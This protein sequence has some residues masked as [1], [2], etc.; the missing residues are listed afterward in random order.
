M[1]SYTPIRFEIPT[2]LDETGLMLGLQRLPEE[3]L[4]TYRK[5]LLLETTE[6]SGPS[7]HQFITAVGRK[8]GQFDEAMFDVDVIRDVNDDPL[9]PDPYIEVTST[10]LRA[11]SDWTNL[12]LDFELNLV[13]RTDAYFLREVFTAFD[14]ST[15]FDITLSDTGYTFKL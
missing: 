12:T 7:E 8:V 3:S 1:G 2:G 11:Y 15:F 9:A 13:S 4:A 5:R 10:Y 14:A 6:R